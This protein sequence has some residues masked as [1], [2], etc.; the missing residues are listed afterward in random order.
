MRG[1]LF[2]IGMAVVILITSACGSDAPEPRERTKTV[3]EKEENVVK[4]TEEMIIMAEIGEE[5]VEINMY[6]NPTSRDFIDQLPLELSFKD[7][8][9]FEKLS[10]PPKKL[11]T[12]GA[13]EGDTPSAGDFAYY[14][15]W[16]DVTLYYKDESYAKGVVLMGRIEDG[17][18]EK[19]AGMGEDEVVRLRNLEKPL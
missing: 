4:P 6:D 3:T 19:V 5:E 17:G 15:P 7:F 9:G 13:P 8:G 11:T 1:K 2:G 10:Y 16:G 18:I 12:E 14:A